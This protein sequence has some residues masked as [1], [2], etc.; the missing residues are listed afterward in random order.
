MNDFQASQ[1]ASAPGGI[2]VGTVVYEGVQGWSAEAPPVDERY[3][4]GV[5][6]CNTDGR[7]L[8]MLVGTVKAAAILGNPTDLPATIEVV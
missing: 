8:V 1:W 5:V 2:P 3:R 7:S 6:W 4:V